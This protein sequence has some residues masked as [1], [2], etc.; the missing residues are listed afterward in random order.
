M[1]DK[2]DVTVLEVLRRKQGWSQADV[3]LA[4]GMTQIRVS[5]IERG[6]RPN[7]EQLRA[8]SG[9]FGVPE[10]LD[11][12]LLERVQPQVPEVPDPP[13]IGERIRAMAAAREKKQ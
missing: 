4:T 10:T 5:E 6:L 11:Y 12:V 7:A 9:L 3:G 1:R 2:R 8:L 13:D